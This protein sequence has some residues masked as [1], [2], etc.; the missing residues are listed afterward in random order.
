MSKRTLQDYL[1]EKN[2][3]EDDLL[4]LLESGI[5]QTGLKHFDYSSYF[6]EYG[7]EDEIENLENI[8]LK[9]F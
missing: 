8:C 6:E 3:T 1:K 4:E 9:L 2:V 5:L 7:T